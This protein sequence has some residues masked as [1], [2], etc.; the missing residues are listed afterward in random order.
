MDNKILIIGGGIAGL[1][2]GIYAQKNG[3]QATIIEMHDK[4]GG[5]LTAWDRNGYRFDYCLHW[6]VGTDHGTYHD[7]WKETNAI[8]NE[9]EVINHE[10]FIRIVD[11]QK[12]DFLIYNNLDKWEAYLLD[13]A[14]ED[15]KAIKKMCR[16]MRKSDGFDQFEHPPGMRTIGNYFKML[17]DA[18][19]FIPI[20]LRYGKKTCHEFFDS[21]GIQNDQLRFFLNKLFGGRD[22]SA[23]GFMMMMG[24]A[25]AKNAGYLK[26]GSFEMSK[27][28]AQKFQDLNGKFL[29][30]SRVKEII[31]ENNTAKGIQLENGETFYADHIIS[32]C[33]G[34]QVLFEMLKGQYLDDQIKEAYT[35]WELFTPLV[36]IGFG[37]DDKI[38]SKTHN[39]TYF[40]ENLSI[41]QTQVQ[42]YSIMNRSSYDESFAPEGKTTLLMQFESPWENWE[43][44]TGT[45]YLDEK[46]AIRKEAVTLLEKHYPGITTKIETI[47]IATPKTTVRYTGVWKGAY[48]GFMPSTDVL[49]GLPMQLKGLNNFSMVGQWLFPGGG[50]PPSAQ[51]GKWAIEKLCKAK[52]KAFNH[53]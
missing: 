19:S 26:G 12:G 24:W 51:T 13:L 48:E 3:F 7:I 4:P 31:V 46:E 17:V 38:T 37:I 45:A 44:L 20:L 1:A 14:P 15:G 32:A 47:D 43:N 6:L 5:Q 29:F 10:V 21:L 30:E 25:H 18:G 28:M 49:S 34:H 42:G 16:I 41:G 33:D 40:D 39:T 52:N 22:F 36:M 9:V 35:N 23:I 53:G 11:Q 50:L 27:R 2:A 8:T